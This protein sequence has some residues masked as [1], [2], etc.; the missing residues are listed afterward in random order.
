[1]LTHILGCTAVLAVLGVA[2]AWVLFQLDKHARAERAAAGRTAAIEQALA[3][4]DPALRAWAASRTTG[5][6]R[7]ASVA[8]MDRMLWEI[9]LADLAPIVALFAEDA[10]AWP[11]TG[12]SA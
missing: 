7:D 1:M 2:G 11:G 5:G 4:A 6:Q 10:P 8:A 12:V 3:N 9:E